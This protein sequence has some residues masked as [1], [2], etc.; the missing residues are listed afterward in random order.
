MADTTK[1]GGSWDNGVE[2]GDLRD[3]GR[4]EVVEVG[5]VDIIETSTNH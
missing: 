3:D 2:V 1:A 4:P 5:K